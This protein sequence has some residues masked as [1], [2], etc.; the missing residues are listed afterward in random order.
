MLGPE[1]LGLEVGQVLRL[2]S[3]PSEPVVIY[4]E[5]EPKLRGFPTVMLFRDGRDLG[6]F[7]GARAAHWITQWIDEHLAAAG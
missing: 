4:I 2:D 5:D 1:L 6:H 3:D 7:A